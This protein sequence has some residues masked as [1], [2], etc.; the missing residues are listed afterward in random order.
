MASERTA[1]WSGLIAAAAAA[2]GVRAE[3]IEAVIEHESAGQPDAVGDG[4]LAKGLMQMHPQAAQDVGVRWADLGDP[5]TAINAGAAYLARMLALFGGDETWALAA[6][7]QGP[8]VMRKGWLYA[9]IVRGV[10]AKSVARAEPVLAGGTEA[11]MGP[12]V[13]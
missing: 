12:K 8:G 6:Y 7:N 5:A 4:G 10:E 9:Q 1:Q 2:S 11:A 3:L 13:S